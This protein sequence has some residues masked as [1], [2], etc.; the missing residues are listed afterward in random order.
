[1]NMTTL[2]NDRQSGARASGEPLGP[3]ITLYGRM[4]PAPGQTEAETDV[5]A[6][7]LR[8]RLERAGVVGRSVLI[9][10]DPRRIDQRLRVFNDP[11][12]QENM[13]GVTDLGTLSVGI[14]GELVFTQ[15][16]TP[17]VPEIPDPRALIIMTGHGVNPWQP[18]PET[19]GA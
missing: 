3:R 4:A 12:V 14:E 10:T 18:A 1:M 13:Q 19:A 11:E 16:E 9:L 2:T 5:V 7:L 17:K 6:D 15:D 8:D